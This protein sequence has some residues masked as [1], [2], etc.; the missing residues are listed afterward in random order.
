MSRRLRPGS[1][2]PLGASRDR[3]GTNFALFSAHAEQVELCLFDPNGRERER[4]TLPEYTDQVWHGYLAGI[5]PGQR[6][7]YR[8][9]GPWA[10]CEGQRFNPAKLLID[11]Y[12]RMLDGPIR[13]H[14]SH[15]GATADG[16]PDP[17]N[18]AAHTPR[19][20]VLDPDES[21]RGTRPDTAWP[22]T[23]IY[24]THVRGFS[25]RHPGVVEALRGS[26]A[27]FASEALIEHLV[28]LGVT[29]VEWLPVQAFADEYFLLERD[30]NNYWGYAPIAWCAPEPR[31]LA[32]Q[33]PDTVRA[34]VERLHQAGIE[35]IIDVVYNHT[36]EGNHLGPTLCYRGIDNRSYYRLHPADPSH[37]IDDA[38]CGNSLNLQHPRVLQL[39]TDSLRHWVERFGVDGFRFDLATALGRTATD[40]DPHAPLL[41]A[42]GQDPILSRCKLIAEPWDVGPGGY[43]LGGFPPGWSEWNDRARD[44]LRRF[45]RGDPDQLPELARRL[46]GSSELFG[47]AG[48]RPWASINFVTSHDGFTLRDLVSYSGKHNEAN[49]EANRDGHHHNF[50]ANHGV[51]GPTE[52]P[53]ILALRD[54]QRR[55]L[56]AS[57]LLSQGTPMLLAGDEF[58][59][60]Q[61][62]NNNAYCQ[63]NPLAWLD[64]GRLASDAAFHGFVRQAI[65][66]RR[67]YPVLRRP[68]FQH[69]QERS[70]STGLADLVWLT[71]DGRPMSE[72]DWHDSEQRSLGLLLAGDAGPYLRAD[73]EPDIDA[74]LLILLNAADGPIEFSLPLPGPWRVELNTA[75]AS[76]AQ[77]RDQ[78]Q[79]PER[80]LLLLVAE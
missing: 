33:N 58:G 53:I 16:K 72:S 50:S 13:C 66:L 12:A 65:A 39:V 26:F 22:D 68:R 45:W 32:G 46:H 54:R 14:P 24:E 25:M 20:I 71:A 60:T 34:T 62:G 1:P 49:R 47:Q 73:G 41:S 7:G 70:P 42:I 52:D 78:V 11:P 64:W 48:R 74:T 61:Q 67:R 27:G 19:S 5:E 18:S 21:Y 40:F 3:Q 44:S 28:D 59:Q 17:R 36:A 56:I 31:Y 63:D 6:Y 10:P 15:Q 79:V 35:V 75:D 30:L 38:G 2:W 80:S 9:H 8:V 51:E 29:A 57:L 43:R 55:N 76:I 23:V 4:I 69:G 77:T 37:Y